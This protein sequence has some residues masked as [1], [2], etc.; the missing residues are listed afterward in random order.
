MIS[1]IDSHVH[2]WELARGDYS[3]L[4]DEMKPIHRDFGVDDFESIRSANN[5]SQLVLVQAAPTVDETRYI[6]ELAAKCDF[7][8]GV[9]GKI[10]IE[11]GDIANE[12]LDEF[13]RQALFCGIRPMLENMGENRWIELPG[14][15][16][17]IRRLI[18]L[19]L[20]FECMV[21]P[22]ELKELTIWLNKFPSLHAI[23]SHAGMPDIKNGEFTYWAERIKHIA[24]ETDV[25]CKL[26]GLT[27]LAAPDWQA[28]TL[29]PYF[30]HLLSCFGHER[31]IWG[32]DWPVML[33]AGDYERWCLICDE[34]LEELDESMKRAIYVDNALGFYKLDRKIKN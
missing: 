12:Q 24:S 9:V 25:Y 23:L 28:D 17:T 14:L 16:A 1:K 21:R 22:G 27:T 29:R 26:S 19:D 33:C 15:N 30:E 10:D 11:R 3:W 2:F 31:L 5:V 6:L 13:S 8:S 7:V 4:T 34:L 20:N 18:Q 32:S